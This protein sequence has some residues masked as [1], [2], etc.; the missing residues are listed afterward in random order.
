MEVIMI[1]TINKKHPDPSKRMVRNSYTDWLRRIESHQKLSGTACVCPVKITETKDAYMFFIYEP[2][3]KPGSIATH[4]TGNLLSI[5]GD[6]EKRS[7]AKAG[8]FNDRFLKT[9]SL[10]GNIASGDVH[11]SYRQG[12]VKLVISKRKVGP[13]PGKL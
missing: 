6:V 5:T 12:I 11:T 3:L 1:T 2:G 10:P 8:S 4:I 9:I 13:E 7:T